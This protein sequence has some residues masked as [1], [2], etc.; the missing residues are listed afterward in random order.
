MQSTWTSSRIVALVAAVVLAG[1]G[2]GGG[3]GAG[4][5]TP[6]PLP[7]TPTPAVTAT[8]GPTPT[9]APSPFVIVSDVADD[10]F[11]QVAF[12]D[13]QY[14]TTFSQPGAD[15][16]RE[17]LGLRLATSGEVL[18][19][20]PLLLSELDPDASAELSE[21]SYQHSAVAG[22]DAGFGVFFAGSGRLRESG[23]PTQV[24]GF[25]SVPTSGS[26]VLPATV[27]DSQV[28]FS[29]VQTSIT[30]VSAATSVGSRFTALYRRVTTASFQPLPIGQV[31][32][33]D[34]VVQGGAVAVERTYVVGG[35]NVEDGVLHT[36]GPGS[37]A[38]A[39]SAELAVWLEDAI[40]GSRPA[41]PVVRT[42]TLQGA[43][44]KPAGTTPLALVDVLDEPGEAA[45]GSDG[46]TF[47]VAWSVGTQAAAPPS[48]IR[49]LR[50]LPGDGSDPG[51]VDPPGG[52]VV[53]DG[54]TAKSV[55]GVAHAAGTW[56]VA[57]LDE[58]ILR[59]ARLAPNGTTA[60]PFTIYPDPVNAAA[61]TSDG[62][63]FLVVAERPTEPSI[64][65]IGQ[66]VPATD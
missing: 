50:Y 47:L 61:L 9:A 45:I 27:V 3:G 35:G 13:D 8:S 34:V 65:L 32:G 19:A 11:P 54:P 22:G 38:S 44:R 10:T 30:G 31:D 57:W 2:G 6:T 37:I 41:P 36:A 28:S 4:S 7:A 39:G 52:F 66:F 53:A 16:R 49:A 59:G 17:V 25:T 43:L 48:E 24:V 23:A 40:D 12:A 58:G 60:T 62:E 42:V 26:P 51:T 29:M 15:E 55:V 21:M 14:L 33:A 46:S 64:D 56:L 63:R 5:P 20:A 18:D 1:C